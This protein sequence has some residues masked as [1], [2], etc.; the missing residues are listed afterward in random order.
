[1]VSELD[2]ERL[3]ARRLNLEGGGHEAVC[4]QGSWAQKGDGLGG[5]TSIGEGNDCQRELW[6]SKGVDCEIP[7][8][9]GRRTK[10]Y[11]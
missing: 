3:L 10:H 2:I 1:M 4:Q 7:H 5:P 11:L 6:V 9:L 8:Q